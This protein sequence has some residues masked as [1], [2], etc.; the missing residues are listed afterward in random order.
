MEWYLHSLA[1]QQ[2]N[3]L[4]IQFPACANVGVLFSLEIL[5]Q[6]VACFD[7]VA[8]FSD[9]NG[10]FEL[11]GPGFAPYSSNAFYTLE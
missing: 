2:Q 8:L 5:P 9:F 4:N 1:A 11:L 3:K 10:L 7:Q 6:T